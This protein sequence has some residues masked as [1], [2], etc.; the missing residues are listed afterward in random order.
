MRNYKCCFSRITPV[1]GRLLIYLKINTFNPQAT[2]FF[3]DVVYGTI[4]QRRQQP[5]WSCFL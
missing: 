4:A 2:A 3:R 1:L 5:G